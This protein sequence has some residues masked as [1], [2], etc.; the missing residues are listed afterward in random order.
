[1]A[2][3]QP[4]PCVDGTLAHHW[5]LTP[6]LM[7][8]GRCQRCGQVRRFDTPL[9]VFKTRLKIPEMTHERSAVRLPKGPGPAA[10][11]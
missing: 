3:E 8:E 6:G 11:A 5:L 2:T 10:A 9:P 7:A 1:M 4:G